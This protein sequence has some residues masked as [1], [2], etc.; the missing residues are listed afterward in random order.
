MRQT[1]SN[2]IDRVFFLDN[3]RYF[4]V[5]LVVVLHAACGYSRF[6]FW[7]P[8][9]DVNAPFFDT[10]LVF[11]DIFLMPGLFFISGYFTL[12]SLQ[13]ENNS[14]L[15]FIKKKL[16]RLGAP[17]LI[18]VI[19]LGPVKTWIYDYTRYDRL[20]L[21][22]SFITNTR[23]MFSFHTGPITS[24]YQFSHLHFWYISLLLLFFI[25]FAVVHRYMLPLP[26]KRSSVDTVPSGKS[27][28]VK[29]FAVGMVS[30]VITFFIHGLFAQSTNKDPWVMVLNLVQFQPT[31]ITLYILIFG[32]GIYAYHKQWFSNGKVPGH[33]FFW[34]ILSGILWVIWKKAFALIIQS[35]SI[36]LAMIL[37][38][39]RPIL[40][41]SILMSLLSFGLK[42][43]Q[44]DSKINRAF[45]DNS[46]SIYLVHM[47]FIYVMQL[48]LKLAGHLNL[49]QI[50]HSGCLSNRIGVLFSAIIF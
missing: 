7:W 37:V 25:C 17:L 32:L 2:P 22:K 18:G 19:L 20:D 48:L 12:P 26:D 33:F 34:I 1:I 10:L 36:Q 44:S 4:L 31:K 6:T 49:Y 47:F 5:L 15:G 3:I 9:N 38:F 39:L 24:S 23:S 11:F 28:L 30:A 50:Y 29:L 8:V 46:Y 16:K 21:W 41:F 14:A 42:F 13:K 35:F 40:F 43:W 27:I 45:S